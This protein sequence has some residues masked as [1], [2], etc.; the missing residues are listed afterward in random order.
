MVEAQE[1]IMT[2]KLAKFFE[3]SDEPVL[4]SAVVLKVTSFG[5]ESKVKF[6]LSGDNFYLFNTQDKLIRG[7]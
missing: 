2:E 5:K 1:D 4:Y 7:Y 6:C 3:S